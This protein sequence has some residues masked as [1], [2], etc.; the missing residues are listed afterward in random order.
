MENSDSKNYILACDIGGTNSRFRVIQ[1]CKNDPTYRELVYED[2][3]L[4]FILVNLA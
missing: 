1:R 4:M 2:V 3:S